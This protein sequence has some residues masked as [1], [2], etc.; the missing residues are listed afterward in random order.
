MGEKIEVIG[1]RRNERQRK[2]RGRIKKEDKC[3]MVE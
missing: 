2:S 3:N 1:R